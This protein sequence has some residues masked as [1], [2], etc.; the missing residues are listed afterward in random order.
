[1]NSTLVRGSR[2]E[3]SR[4]S[5]RTDYPRTPCRGNKYRQT[6]ALTLGHAA[7]TRR[8]RLSRRRLL[9]GSVRSRWARRRRRGARIP[10]RTPPDR[11][12]AEELDVGGWPGAR[13]LRIGFISDLHRSGTVSHEMSRA[14]SVL[15]GTSRTS[16]S[17]AATMSPITI[18]VSCSRRLKRWPG[19]GAD[20]V[21]AVL[22][23]HD[24]ERDMPAALGRGFTVLRDARTQIRIR[25][26]I[27]DIA[28]LR[29]WT[30]RMPT[31]RVWC[32]ARRQPD[33]DRPHAQA[34]HRS[35]GA[36]GA[37]DA[38]RPHPRRADRPAGN[39][40][41]GRARVPV[42]AGAPGGTTPRPS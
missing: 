7:P 14:R 13:R 4:A 30:R 3:G 29:Y 22:G 6:R 27:V 24:D 17:S 23:N 36:V 11:G 25:G 19:C 31:S 15:M 10:V 26:E 28:G 41:G 18:A 16:S 40:R 20:G 34:A 1:M 33:P 9:R 38:Q 42:V 37:A 12:H 35:R 5:C 39:R 2:V 8:G 32:A 21:Y